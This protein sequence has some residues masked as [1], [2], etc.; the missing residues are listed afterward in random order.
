MLKVVHI[1]TRFVNGGA[2]ENTLLTCN[3]Q[4]Q[5]GH[6]VWLFYGPD[7]TE[8]MMALLDPRVEARCIGSLAREVKI[9][10]DLGAAFAIARL[11]RAIRPDIVHTHTSKA[12]IVG[13][14]ASLAAPRAKVVHG[15]HILPF[16]GVSLPKKIFY[17]LLEKLAALRTHAFID[18]SEGMRDLCLENRLGRETTHHVICS[19]MDVEKFRRAPVA[20][21]LIERLT[22]EGAAAPIAIVYVAVMERRKR[23]EELLKAVAPVL[24][25]RS[26]IHLLLAG[27]GPE[28]PVLAALIEK[29]GLAG[30]IHLLG[31]RDDAEAVIAASD[32]CV[33]ASEREGLPR[34]I[35]QYAIAGKP[36]V[37]TALPGIEL[38]VRDGVG[39][40]VVAVDD[41]AGLAARLTQL[42][43]DPALRR[44]MAASS[45]ALD[46]SRWDARAMTTQIESVYRDLLSSPP[47]PGLRGGRS[48]VGVVPR[49]NTP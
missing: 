3:H 30:Q 6:R 21:D 32:I 11:L 27:D 23:H 28:R 38:V 25:A 5:A 48:D 39:G 19:G 42:S 43:D 46:F 18:V 20:P 26:H 13:R 22:R 49:S 1:I 45:A 37:A 35:V 2:D 29:V 33:F 47:S 17:L 24:A 12:G 16:T 8:R 41:F 14:L 34:A 10:K 4:A 7:F 15:V 36:I 9:A 31:F 44:T 40:Y